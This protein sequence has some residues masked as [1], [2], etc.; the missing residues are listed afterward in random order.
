MVL[1]VTGLAVGV[2]AS[3]AS[4][5]ALLKRSVP[6]DGSTVSQAPRAI[7]LFFTEPPELSLSSVT[8]LDSSGNPVH[9]IGP[10]QP[11]PGTPDELSVAVGTGSLPDGVYTVA[12]R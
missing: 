9:G 6:A 5:H 10:P 7:Q 11:V 8:V 2:G 4:A 3:A 1:L 12:W